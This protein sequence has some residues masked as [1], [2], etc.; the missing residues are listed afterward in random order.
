MDCSMPG[1]P[2]LHC[3]PDPCPLSQWCYLIIS[4]SAAPFSYCRQSFPTSGSFPA[5]QLVSSGGQST[6]ASVTVFPMNIQGWFPLGLIGLISL[7]SKGLS[8]VFSST[9]VWKHQFF[10][11]HPSLWSSSHSCTWLLIYSS[12]WTVK[13]SF[14]ILKIVR[15]WLKQYKMYVLLWTYWYF[16]VFNS[17][18][19]VFSLIHI[20]LCVLW[21]NFTI[22]IQVLCFSS[23]Y[24]WVF[25]KLHPLW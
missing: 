3:L 17:G 2:V 6:G 12:K 14:L 13:P 23:I 5:S 4:S 20:F 15:F 25:C 21:Q 18:T 11:I 22:L 8:R 9:T 10:S 1:F 19:D 24:S 7:L 16:K